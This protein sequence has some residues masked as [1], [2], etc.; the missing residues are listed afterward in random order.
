VRHE[1]KDFVTA[2][3]LD[4]F[5]KRR[6]NGLDELRLPIADPISADFN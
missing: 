6:V 3:N 2:W 1:P 4:G 5:D